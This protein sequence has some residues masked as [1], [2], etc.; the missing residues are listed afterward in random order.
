M[1]YMNRVDWDV[2]T[3]NSNVVD[4]ECLIDT[5]G[6]TDSDIKSTLKTAGTL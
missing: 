6:D 1:D 4:D 2:F 3:Y 5:L